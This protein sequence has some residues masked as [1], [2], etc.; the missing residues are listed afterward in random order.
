MDS[1][2]YGH[3]FNNIFEALKRVALPSPLLVVFKELNLYS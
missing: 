1:C 2:A 3:C